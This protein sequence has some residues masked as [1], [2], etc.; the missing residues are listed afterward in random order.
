MKESRGA[1]VRDE[2]HPV[3]LHVGSRVRMRRH[4]LRLSQSALAGAVGLTFQQIQ[5]YERGANRISASKL[6]E[7][8]VFLKMPIGGF[9]EGYG[10]VEDGEISA[11][12]AEINAFLA[13]TEGIE[14][15]RAF[16]LIRQPKQRRRILELI[17]SMGESTD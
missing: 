15:A 8:A 3:D 13:T 12:E 10:H 7:I 5:K 11:T 4:F 1:A 14:L 16:P 17:R 9:F 6:L 2:P